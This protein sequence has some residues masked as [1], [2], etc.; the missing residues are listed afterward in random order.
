MAITITAKSKDFTKVEEYLMTIAP[1]IISLKDL[2]DETSIP[3]DGWLEYTEEE[4]GKEVAIMSIIT[5]DR[6][7][8]GFQSATAKRS[9]LDI[10]SIMEGNKYSVIK[11]SGTTKAG[12][13]YVNLILDI[14]KL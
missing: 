8:Y 1:N 14:S 12:R 5:P 9:L 6:E 11:I 4:N 3:V 7:V 10:D 13:P 2:E